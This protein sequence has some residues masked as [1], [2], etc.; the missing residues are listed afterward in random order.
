MIIS[1]PALHWVP[2]PRWHLAELVG[3][4][5]VRGLF[6]VHLDGEIMFIGRAAAEDSG[7]KTRLDSYRR[8]KGSGRNHYAGR[9][10]YEH[11]AEIEMQI[12]TL[13]LPPFEINRLADCLIADL[14]PRWNVPRDAQHN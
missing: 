13:D 7:L 14:Q 3:F 4:T 2:I 12:A 8:R 11:R 1:K 6:R 5:R 10:I 9:M